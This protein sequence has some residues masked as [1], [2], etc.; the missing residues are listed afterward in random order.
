M[1][2]QN[3]LLKQFCIFIIAIFLFNSCSKEEINEPDENV[4]IRLDDQI[5]S[6]DTESDFESAVEKIQNNEKIFFPN[7]FISLSEFNNGLLKSD[8]GVED[9]L[10]YSEIFKNMVNSDYEIIVSG[11][12]YKV[13][14]YGTMFA[15][16]DFI[17]EL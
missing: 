15:R 6:F 11:V 17:N 16:T 5:L 10:I 7:G 1:K 4:S 9:T 2:Y 3:R 8:G 13:T 12:L 14:P